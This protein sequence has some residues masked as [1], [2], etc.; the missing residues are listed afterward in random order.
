MQEKLEN[1][2]VFNLKDF[3]DIKCDEKNLEKF[4]GYGNNRK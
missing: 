3:V 2:L 4:L 1:I